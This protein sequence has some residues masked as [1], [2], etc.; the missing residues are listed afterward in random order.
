MALQKE[1]SLIEDTISHAQ[2]FY[3]GA[4]RLLNTRI[5]T[6]P[7]LLIARLFHFNYRQYF[8]LDIDV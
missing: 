2:R 4:V 5:D 6:F 1:L 7:D 8:Q 3:N